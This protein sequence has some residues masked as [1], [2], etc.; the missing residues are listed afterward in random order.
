MTKVE[1]M[2]P[3]PKRKGQH[4]YWEEVLA[5]LV[6]NPGRWARIDIAKSLEKAEATTSNL[7]RRLVAIPQPDHDWSFVS[8]EREVYAIY[9][10]KGVR[11]G[12]RVRRTKRKR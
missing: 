2:D 1:F 9:R 11:R 10:G 8:R 5:P 12:K 7:Q 6:K 3:P 4:G